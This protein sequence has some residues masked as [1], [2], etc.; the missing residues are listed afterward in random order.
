M[1]L[2]WVVNS[3][4]SPRKLQCISIPNHQVTGWGQT[5]KS[6]STVTNSGLGGELR[7]VC[8]TGGDEAVCWNG[9]S[10]GLESRMSLSC[11]LKCLTGSLGSLVLK[12]RG[13]VWGLS[14]A[15]PF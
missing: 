12:G 9:N 6:S 4:R 13:G 3:D 5:V 7:Y 1:K 8:V 14:G 2:G 10:L 11:S 15:Y